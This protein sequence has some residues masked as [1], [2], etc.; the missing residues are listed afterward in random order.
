[1]FS[2]DAEKIR[3]LLEAEGEFHSFLQSNGEVEVDQSSGRP[4]D[5]EDKDLSS[6][7]RTV[8]TSPPKYTTNY[9]G[10]KQKL[11][12]W[13][14]GNT[15]DGSGSAV[16][17]FSGSSVVGYMYKSKFAHQAPCRNAG[18]RSHLHQLCAFCATNK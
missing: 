17:A 8:P 12:D 1:M 16:D 14:W 9:I 11:I 2:T 3:Y 18:A 5:D 15:P 6:A 13:I 4:L 7:A 10:S